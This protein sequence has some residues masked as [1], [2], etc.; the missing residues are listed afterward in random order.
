MTL[1]SQGRTSDLRPEG[2][3]S[4]VRPATIALVGV[5]AVVTVVGLLAYLAGVEPAGPLLF[6]AGPAV[7]AVLVACTAFLPSAVPSRRRVGPLGIA[8]LV[9]PPVIGLASAIAL[10]VGLAIPVVRGWVRRAVQDPTSL[11]HDHD[12]V[13]VQLALVG[14]VPAGCALAGVLA[15]ALVALAVVCVVGTV[16]SV[17]ARVVGGR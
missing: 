3:W 15:A 7:L 13:G 5:A 2:R 6:L 4:G 9:V 17:H 8:V 12:A 14:L 1:A 16:R 10:A 11:L